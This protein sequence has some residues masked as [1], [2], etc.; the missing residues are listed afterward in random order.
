MTPKKIFVLSILVVIAVAALFL[1]RPASAGTVKLSNTDAIE[2]LS[3]RFNDKHIDPEKGSST[4]YSLPVGSYTLQATATG[5]TPFTA[6][7]TVHKKDTLTINITL[8]PTTDPTIQTIGQIILPSSAPSNMSITN[9]TYFYNKTWA[10]IA[11]KIPDGDTG[12]MATQYNAADG[13]WL[14]KLGPG[15]LFAQSDVQTLPSAVATYMEQYVDT[16]G[17]E[18]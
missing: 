13:T 8:K 6:R 9:T 7:F 4:T 14:T 17:G 16:S 2:G 11:V 12:V 10:V 15:T 1:V 5:Y 18:E 3:V